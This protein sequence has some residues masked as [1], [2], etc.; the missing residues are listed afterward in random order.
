[1]PANGDCLFLAIL[2]CIGFSDEVEDKKK[3]ISQWDP[4]IDED[5][6]YAR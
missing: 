2:R 6:R 4:N 5:I 1:V 3:G